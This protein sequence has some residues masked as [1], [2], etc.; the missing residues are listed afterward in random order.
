MI[1]TRLVWISESSKET[2]GMVPQK[3][4]YSTKHHLNVAEGKCLAL[5]PVYLVA[6]TCF[7]LVVLLFFVF[8][9][10]EIS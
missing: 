5:G 9:C 8:Y 10:F 3:A 7:C 4:Y 1:P 2:N 6:Q